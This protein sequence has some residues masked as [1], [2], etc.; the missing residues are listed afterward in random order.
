[1]GFYTQMRLLVCGSRHWT[2]KAAMERLLS[3][4]Q[5]WNL[6]GT[7]IDT[8]IEGEANGAD[9]LAKAVA[10]EMGI[11]VEPYPA[12]WDRYGKAAGPIRNRQMLKHAKPDAVLA[13]HRNIARSRGTL[14]MVNCAIR[15]GI[16]T[17]LWNGI[18]LKQITKRIMGL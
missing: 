2:D 12:D 4:C 16:P 1:M 7:R 15:M 5:E 18:E 6:N 14:D 17:F 13:F 3:T 11:P 10:T 9:K 8:V